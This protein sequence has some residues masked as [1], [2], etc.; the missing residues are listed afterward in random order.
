[1]EEGS[2]EE[3]EKDG[4]RAEVFSDGGQ[5]GRLVQVKE[6]VEWEVKWGGGGVNPDIRSVLRWIGAG[7]A[8]S[9]LLSVVRGME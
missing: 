4:D 5:E 3:Q 7:Q 1:M 8:G 9:Y 2:G 6:V